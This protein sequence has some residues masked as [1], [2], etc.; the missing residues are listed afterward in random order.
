MKK[1]LLFGFILLFLLVGCSQKDASLKGEYDLTGVITEI[2][3][4]GKQ[5]LVEDKQIGLVWISLPEGSDVNVYQVGQTV[6]VWSDGKI[7]ESYPAQT[8]ALHIEILTT[9]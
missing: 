2:N 9:N 3:S 1:T 4:E 5:I 6:A 8:N 7:R